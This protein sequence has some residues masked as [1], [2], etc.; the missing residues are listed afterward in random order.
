MKLSRLGMVVGVI[1]L[2]AGGGTAAAGGGGR[3][4]WRRVHVEFTPTELSV[5]DAGTICDPGGTCV[6]ASTITKV[7]QTGDLVGDTVEEDLIGSRATDG[8][9]LP[10]VI[11]GTFNG[12]IKGCDTG[13]HG[14]GGAF[15]YAGTATFDPS[16]FA[17]G[18]ATYTIIEGTGTGSLAGIT[19]TLVNGF[20][21]DPDPATITGTVRCRAPH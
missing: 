4:G 15:L 9:V 18:S 10:E 12:T 6:T 5:A 7:K 1:A 20:P 14:D 11:M 16:T 21:G 13:V 2:A 17:R 3:G 8:A 19:G